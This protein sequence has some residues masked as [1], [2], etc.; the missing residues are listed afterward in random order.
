MIWSP[1]S[2]AAASGDVLGIGPLRDSS[3]AD[4]LS[5]LQSWVAECVSNHNCGRSKG[6]DREDV[7]TNPELPNRIL[8]IG[9]DDSGSMVVRLVESR[10][11]HG[12]YAALS[13][14]WGPPDKQPLRTTKATY[15]QHLAGI[16]ASGLPKTFREAAQ[17]TQAVG[18]RYIWIDSLCIIQDDRDDWS[19]EAP[20]MGPLYGKAYLVIAASGATNSTEGCFVPQRPPGPSLQ[21]PYLSAGGGQESHVVLQVRQSYTALSPVFSPLGKRGWV[22]Q[23][24]KLARRLVHYTAAGMTW[25][26]KQVQDMGEDG[27][28]STGTSQDDE[29][30]WDGIIE[31]YTIRQLTYLSDKIVAVQ[32]LAEAMQRSLENAAY[33]HGM[34]TS[35][36]P[37]QLF[38]IGTHTRRPKELQHIPSWSWASTDGRCLTLS[39][40]KLSWETLQATFAV[41]KGRELVVS[42]RSKGC[43]LKRW[44]EFS[45]LAVTEPPLSKA[46]VP[47][48]VMYDLPIH[49]TRKMTHL[50]LDED[51]E[52]VVGIAMLD[53]VEAAGERVQDCI[54]AF[55]MKEVRQGNQTQAHCLTYFSLV[56]Q[57]VG[58]SSRVYRR[59]GV[60]FAV[61][62]DWVHGGTEQTFRIF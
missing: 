7:T 30:V 33:H 57:S 27:M 31:S 59:L 12:S 44:K 16:A 18:L 1:R 13:H 5:I 54:S 53:D 28:H 52:E 37:Q 14:C 2:P 55:F 10:G 11:M 15:S 34:W 8:D 45:H 39:H 60:G 9:T 21:I 56:L 49:Y 47:G 17:I 43:S 61:D 29:L 40:R 62:E 41:E 6:A 35:D 19:R 32:G 50:M 4:S 24:W 58:S 36:M 25:S 48:S 46:S 42:C 26:C 51:T 3:S 38:W 22:L 23:E 20:R